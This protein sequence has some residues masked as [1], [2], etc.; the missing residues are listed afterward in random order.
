[1]QGVPKLYGVLAMCL[2][3]SMYSMCLESLSVLTCSY[4]IRYCRDYEA[5]KYRSI[6]AL[7]KACVCVCE[8]L[9]YSRQ[10]RCRPTI[11]HTHT[12]TLYTHQQHMLLKV[13]EPTRK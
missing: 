13:T 4:P 11:T 10:S 2:S 6:T 12:Q 1:M 5:S 7:T 8:G 3:V 9:Y